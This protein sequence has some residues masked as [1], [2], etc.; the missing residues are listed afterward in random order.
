MAA[1]VTV[2]AAAARGGGVNDQKVYRYLPFLVNDTEAAPTPTA[3]LLPSPTPSPIS[4][5]TPEPTA[6]PTPKPTA[7]P[8]D[9][10]L[11]N[12]WALGVNNLP[13]CPGDIGAAWTHS[14]TVS[15]SVCPKNPSPY[16]PGEAG[17]AF[18]NGPFMG[19]GRPGIETISIQEFIA[20]PGAVHSF[21]FSAL[22]ICVRCDYLRA[23]LYA[24]D[25]FLGR[26]LDFSPASIPSSTAEDWPR[27]TGPIVTAP[28]YDTYQIVIRSMFTNNEALGV[29]WTGLIL[30]IDKGS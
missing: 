7:A 21:K 27:Y 25:L 16:G 20:P 1:A 18:K 14:E 8:V 6:A 30:S 23:D 9:N 26:L 17:A 11:L 10:A 3:P 4:S 24:G 28:H 5:P 13:G 22:V 29:K 12:N 19:P 2:M 15:L